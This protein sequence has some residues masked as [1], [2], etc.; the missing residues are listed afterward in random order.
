VSVTGKV[1]FFN[2]TKGYLNGTPQ[3]VGSYS[4]TTPNTLSFTAPPGAGVVVSAD[5]AY[6]SQC[7]FLDDQMEF[8]E[9]MSSLWKLKSMKFRSVKSGL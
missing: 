5:F 4:L 9:F 1:K 6:A 7:R 8:E 3:S 2:D